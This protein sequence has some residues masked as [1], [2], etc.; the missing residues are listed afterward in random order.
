MVM[1]RRTWLQQ[2]LHQRQIAQQAGAAVALDHLI[3]GAA[4]VDIEDIEA[5]VLA[6]A[7]GIGHHGRVGAEELRGD[8]M[9]FG[10]ECQILQG[11]VGLSRSQ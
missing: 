1:A 8:R 4:E 6:D 7:R 11:L 10:I 9:L 2:T 5:Q 3:H